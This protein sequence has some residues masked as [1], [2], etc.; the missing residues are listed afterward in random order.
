MILDTQ[1]SELLI[2]LSATAILGGFKYIKV[3][4]ANF[5]AYR[6]CATVDKPNAFLLSTDFDWFTNTCSQNGREAENI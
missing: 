6:N 3:E 4:A 1:G 5:E 2:L